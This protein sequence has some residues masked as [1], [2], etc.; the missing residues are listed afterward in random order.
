[1]AESGAAPTFCLIVPAGT[2]N[3]AALADAIRAHH[4]D[5]SIIAV[6]CGDPHRRPRLPATVSWADIG[7]VEPLGI[8]WGLLLAALPQRAYEWARTVAVLAT[9]LSS[10]SGAIAVM[11]VGSVAVLG[12]CEPLF[13]GSPISLVGRGPLP[14]VDD[15]LAPTDLDLLREGAVSTVMAAFRRGSEDALSWLAQRLLDSGGHT[16]PLLERM[17]ELFG[18]AVSADARIGAGPWRGATAEPP[19]LVDLEHFDAGEPW[20]FTIGVHPARVRLSR[21]PQLA[22]AVAA[23]RA[24]V[25]GT[26]AGLFLPGGIRVDQAMRLA[27]R[28]EIGRITQ[29]AG[30][31]SE[32]PPQPFGPANSRFIE[33]LESA[34]RGSAEIGRYWDCLHSTR[35]DLAAAFVDLTGADLARYR[36][37]TRVSW[38]LED[39]SA[40][41]ASHTGPSTSLAD[42]D[43]DPS[44]I[45]VL[46]Y[47]GVDQS[48][49]AVARRIIGALNA[50]EVPVA[51]LE[52]HRAMESKRVTDESWENE[53]RF[54]TNIC[55]ITADQFGFVLA[56]HPALLR[57][58]RTIAYWFWELEHVP[59]RFLEAIDHVD[60]I[61]T[62][63]RFV[64]DAF[65]AVTSK[66]VRCV[67][68]P[69]TEPHPST[70]DRASMGLPD[71]AYVFV[72]TFDQFSVP[73][74]KN[75]FGSIDAFTRAFADG[76]G[77]VLLIKT[78]NGERGWRNH[79]RL[80]LAASGRSDI[81]VWDEHLS[82][83]DQMAVLAN[84]DCLVSLHRSE[85]LGLHCAEAM[86]LG[87]PVIATRYSGNLD[88]MDDTVAVMIDFTYINVSNGEGI[89]PDT[90]V[91]ADPDLDQAADWMRRLVHEPRLGTELGARARQRMQAQPSLADTGRLIARLANLVPKSEAGR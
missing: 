84:A 36:S 82:R 81:I 46:G 35:A 30:A 89:Y 19:S 76:E 37:W 74:R 34:P 78:V 83:G 69:V 28:R 40:L 27:V 16:G 55:V 29:L 91:W 3:T 10:T 11:R 4:T 32:L 79:E 56:D 66:P 63:S 50:A 22:A 9:E 77:P 31:G 47:L 26:S 54:A 61:W 20:H 51:R 8:G 2:W 59:E 7:V 21:D 18:G 60:E 57:D 38:R 5:S 67:P 15:G 68:L 1:M 48:L 45:N 12:D 71:D 62:G 90:A 43:R 13:A 75:P 24:Q 73:E 39:R 87:K 88:F 6:W 85:G 23:G 52:H 86:W 70:R 33:W 65:A 41:L 64:A 14:V 49:G 80:L 58:R 53:A 42:V 17:G 72:T 44:G 25:V